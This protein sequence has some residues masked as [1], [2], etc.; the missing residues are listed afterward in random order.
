MYV[1]YYTFIVFHTTANVVFFFWRNSRIM[2]KQEVFLL[3]LLKIQPV[4]KQENNNV[5][6]KI[7]I[8]KT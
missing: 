6:K 5:V 4:Q 8:I 1:Y 3:N 2:L 7:A